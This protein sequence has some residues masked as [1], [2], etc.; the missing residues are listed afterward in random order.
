MGQKEQK[1]LKQEEQKHPR[2]LVSGFD[3]LLVIAL[4]NTI[5]GKKFPKRTK[6]RAIRIR[7]L[8]KH[9]ENNT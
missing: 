3:N 2:L 6:V 4:S 9:K 1:P 8:K 5:G 7:K